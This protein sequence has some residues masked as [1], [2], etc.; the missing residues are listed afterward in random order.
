MTDAVQDIIQGK[1]VTIPKLGSFY[2]T[3]QKE[4]RIMDVN[5]KEY[6]VLPARNKVKYNPNKWIRTQMIKKE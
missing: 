5:T 1:N 4:K 2:M 6:C 3:E